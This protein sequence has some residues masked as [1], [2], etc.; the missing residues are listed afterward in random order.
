MSQDIISDVLNQIMNA[1]RAG[2]L[3]LEVNHS[4]KSLISIL[5]LAKLKGYIKNYELT[6]KS[7]K[8]EIGRLNA[9]NAIKPRYTIIV[10]QIEKYEK[11][12]LPARGFGILILSTSKGL[13]TNQTAKEKNIGGSLIAYMY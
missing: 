3:D 6:K 10:S 9:C 1:K 13:M 7:L 2:K 8:I 4:S 5:A 12:Y 11:R